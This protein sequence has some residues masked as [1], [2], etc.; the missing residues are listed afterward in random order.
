MSDIE[1]FS[2]AYR[3]RLDEAERAG[4]IPEN[5]SLEVGFP[6]KI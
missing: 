2:S 4:T 6:F 5:V 1:N 3:E